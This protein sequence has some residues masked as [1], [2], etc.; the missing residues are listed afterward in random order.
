MTQDIN[1]IGWATAALCPEF[2]WLHPDLKFTGRDKPK[3]HQQLTVPCKTE[4]KILDHFNLWPCDE[5][6]SKIKVQCWK[7]L[8]SDINF[9]L[10]VFRSDKSDW[11]L[12]EKALI[13]LSLETWTNFGK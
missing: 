9:S 8:F 12:E 1:P 13:K 10:K 2:H 6:V 3:S 7:T 4:L 11:N 5:M